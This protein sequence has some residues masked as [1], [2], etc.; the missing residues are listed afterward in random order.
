[1]LP[2]LCSQTTTVS[3]RNG[4]VG[5]YIVIFC[6]AVWLPPPLFYVFVAAEVTTKG[7]GV[8]RYGL[9]EAVAEF[10][11]ENK[12]DRRA[13][14]EELQWKKKQAEKLDKR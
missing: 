8:A 5:F 1:M 10:A 9:K 14:Y 12:L 4:E 6:V 7:K 13:A 2:S 3:G 11:E